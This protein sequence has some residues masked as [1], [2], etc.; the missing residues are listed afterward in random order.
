M[1]CVVIATS[2]ARVLLIEDSAAEAVVLLHAQARY[3][4]GRY[5]FSAATSMADAVRTLRHDPPDCVVLDLAVADGGVSAVAKVREWLPCAPLIGLAAPGDESQAI[6]AIRD[7]ADDCLEKGDVDARRLCRAIDLAVERSHARSRL[8]GLALKDAVTGL[9]NRAQFQD[10]LMR[11]VA[12]A[13]RSQQVL[14]LLCIDLDGFRSINDVFGHETGD[15]LLRAVATRFGRELR[16]G[17]TL[18]RIGG[19]EFAL[20]LENVPSREAAAMVARKLLRTLEAP[21]VIG[22]EELAIACSI[23]IAFQPGDGS[24]AHGLMRAADQALSAA[25]RRGGSRI[26]S[27]A[28]LLLDPAPGHAGARFRASADSGLVPVLQPSPSAGEAARCR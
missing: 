2:P 25:K 13:G 26:G 12:R 5:R 7:G 11:A 27:Y 6:A 19:D 10:L 17:D 4:P 18:A 20:I 23:G 14:A 21:L 1:R 3:A 16:S 28:G 22:G 15:V 8:M 24:E 9:P